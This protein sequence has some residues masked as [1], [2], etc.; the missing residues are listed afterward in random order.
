M[1]CFLT[2]MQ[3]PI[4]SEQFILYKCHSLLINM[5]LALADTLGVAIN[6]KIVAFPTLI[7]FIVSLCISYDHLHDENVKLFLSFYWN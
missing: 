4:L 2:L 5:V 1:K 7:N 6:V 3:T